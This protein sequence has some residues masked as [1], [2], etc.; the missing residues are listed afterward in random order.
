MLKKWIAILMAAIL[1]TMTFALA[2]T[3]EEAGSDWTMAVLSD[4]EI[5]GQFPY[6][7]F[8]EVNED[9]E[10]V[11]IVSSTE[12]AF[13]G[14]ED[15]ADVYLCKDGEAELAMSVGGAGGDKFFCNADSHTLTHYWRLSGEEHIE[16]YEVKDGALTPV[17]AVDRYAQN[18]GPAENADAESF[19]QEGEA[20][21]QETCE[22]LF[23]QYADE[24]GLVSYAPV[25]MANP[26]TDMT[27]E[28]LEQASGVTLGLPEGA[29]NVV[30]R[31]MA[32]E[33]LAEMQFTLGADEYC[34]RV[35]PAALEAGQLEDI[36][37]MY[38]A[39]ENVEETTIGGCHGTIGQAQTGSEEFVELCLWYDLAP[40]LM[41]SLSVTTTDVDGLDLAA[42]A[43][44]VY[45]PMQGDA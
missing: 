10:P 36:S 34:A 15:H 42:V 18:H 13:I 41:Y 24:S 38:F 6:H 9:G 14:A 28:A 7:S 4:P 22:A 45:V 44:Q 11:L 5:T 3:A 25:G 8:V 1:L 33:G 29:E 19:F 27:A 40:G 37:G 12:D 43:E 32:A 26:W 31:W 21:S 39:W 16:V 30:Y 35:K 23:A 20:I 17:T 2:E